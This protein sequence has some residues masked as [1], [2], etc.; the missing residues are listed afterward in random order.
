MFSSERESNLP[1]SKYCGRIKAINDASG[2]DLLKNLHHPQLTDYE[3]HEMNTLINTQWLAYEYA[4]WKAIKYP[5]W[6]HILFYKVRVIKMNKFFTKFRKMNLN[7]EFQIHENLMYRISSL[8]W[9]KIDF[10]ISC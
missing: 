3:I 8:S 5:C 9:M 7:K 1:Q 2:L 4:R 10:Q 6:Y